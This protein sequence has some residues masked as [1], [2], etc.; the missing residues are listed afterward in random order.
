M[1]DLVKSVLR[2]AINRDTLGIKRDAAGLIQNGL[3]VATGGLLGNPNAGRQ[4]QTTDQNGVS[5]RPESGAAADPAARANRSMQEFGAQHGI[6]VPQQQ[7]GLLGFLQGIPGRL[8]GVV[9]P[10]EKMVDRLKGGA[11][12]LTET[13]S[14]VADGVANATGRDTNKMVQTPEERKVEVA[15]PAVE[16]E[17]A[18]GA[19]TFPVSMPSSIEARPLPAISTAVSPTTDFKEAASPATAAPAPVA[20]AV[21]T[22]SATSGRFD[23]DTYA[24]AQAFVAKNNPAP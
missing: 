19:Q 17:P 2:G 3:G 4:Q 10:S 18:A 9:L 16:A 24:R 23:A 21:T 22:P 6:G 7:G 12:A 20:T 13:V 11:A 8:A 5:R 1:N 14:G 15:T